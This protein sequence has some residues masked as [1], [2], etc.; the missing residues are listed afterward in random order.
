MTH[1]ITVDLI[2]S[3]D[4]RMRRHV[5]H[6]SRSLDYRTGSKAKP[7]TKASDHKCHVAPWDQGQIGDCTAS[8]GLGLMITEPFWTPTT[9]LYTEVD[10]VRF[11]GMETRLDDSVIPGQYPPQDTGSCGLYMCKTLRKLGLITG[12]QTATGLNAVL[13]TLVDRPV[14]LG[15]VWMDSMEQPDYHGVIK[16]SPQAQ[17]VG[18]HEYEAVGQD[19]ERRLVKIR[20][21]WGE[22]WGDHGYGY[23]SWDDLDRLLHLQGD[24]YT[25][26]LPAAA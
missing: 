19:P 20:Q 1:T 4:P 7:P 8:A 22:E 14:A 9:H 24:C 18:G 6:D 17:Q 15:T 3:R 26:L 5:V 10:C 23:M 21:S 25:P 16:I 12:Y 2:D 13:N 11:Y